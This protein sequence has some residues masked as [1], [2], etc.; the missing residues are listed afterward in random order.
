MSLVHSCRLIK[1]TTKSFFSAFKVKWR[2]C[3]GRINPDKY[4]PFIV[5]ERNK[6]VLYAKL[7]K[8]LYSMLCAAL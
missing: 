3:S 5:Y 7:K 4:K 2:N 1:T 6:R 8:C